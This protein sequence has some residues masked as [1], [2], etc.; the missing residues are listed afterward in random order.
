MNQRANDE[1]EENFR[2]LLINL[3]TGECSK[4]DWKLLLS[5]NSRLFSIQELQNFQIR[6]TFRNKSVF[7]YNCAQ[8]H[9][10]EKPIFYINAK[11]NSKVC[12]IN[13][14]EFGGLNPVLYL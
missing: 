6:L 13:S 10:L 7:D 12:K 1:S 14:D 11:H 4:D 8:L 3:R 2:K 9:Q 5:R